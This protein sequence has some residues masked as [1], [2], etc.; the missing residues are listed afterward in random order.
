MYSRRAYVEWWSGNRY[1]Y[2]PIEFFVTRYVD[3]K[4]FTCTTCPRLPDCSH[5]SDI[6]II[7]PK[8]LFYITDNFIYRNLLRE[9][10]EFFFIAPFVN[11]SFD[12]FLDFLYVFNIRSESR[13]RIKNIGIGSVVLLCCCV[14]SVISSKK[15]YGKNLRSCYNFKY[16]KQ[17]TMKVFKVRSTQV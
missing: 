7:F 9:V 6:L 14:L 17:S 3:I 11:I 2:N 16:H 13:K 4:I 10:F 1:N 15:Q 5:C 8:C 12:M